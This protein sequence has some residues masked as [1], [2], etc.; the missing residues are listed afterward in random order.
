VR[1]AVNELASELKA[2]V[3]VI[4]S[5]NPSI[6]TSAGFKRLQRDPSHAYSGDG[7]QIK[8]EATF[9]WPLDCRC[10]LT[11]FYYAVLVR[12]R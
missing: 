8:K 3:V 7:G 5:R 4:G 11:F 2:D 10:S 12:I 6:T 9:R 1:D